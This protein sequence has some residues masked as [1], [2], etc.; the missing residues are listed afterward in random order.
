MKHLMRVALILARSFFD[1][2][3]AFSAFSQLFGDI[4]LQSIEELA[5]VDSYSRSY[6]WAVL[7]ALELQR[8][9]QILAWMPRCGSG[10]LHSGRVQKWSF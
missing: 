8:G 1:L 9:A 5:S 4:P 10:G 7:A 6:L 2:S 3:G